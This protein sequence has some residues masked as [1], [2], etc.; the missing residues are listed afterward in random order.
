V[1]Q[2]GLAVQ[3]S[4]MFALI[5][6]DRDYDCID[7]V[8]CLGSFPTEQEALDLKKKI[9]DKCLLSF[10]EWQRY[11]DKYVDDIEVPKTDYE[12]WIQ[13]L[14]KFGFARRHISPVDFKS[15]F[16]SYLKNYCAAVKLQD[17]N[18]PKRILGYE[19]LFVVE[20]KPESI[21]LNELVF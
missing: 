18:P 16:K 8:E 7:N 20:I 11:I 14:N 5:K 4:K 2:A 1:E 3:E 19:D 15:S 13:F 21:D 17:F 6:V 9:Q 12:G 10:S